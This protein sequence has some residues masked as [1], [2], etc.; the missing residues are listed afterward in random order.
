MA[1]P[2]DD[3]ASAFDIDLNGLLFPNGAF[4]ADKPMFGIAYSKAALDG[5]VRQ[6][7]PA[8]CAGL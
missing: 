7:S 8:C 6:T 3:L 5:W 1:E 2:D 4:P